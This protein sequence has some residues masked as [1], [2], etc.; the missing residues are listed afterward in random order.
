MEAPAGQRPKIGN[1]QAPGTVT[2]RGAAGADAGWIAVSSVVAV[3]GFAAGIPDPSP[4]VAMPSVDPGAV[5]FCATGARTTEARVPVGPDSSVD[6]AARTGGVPVV[7]AVA[8]LAGVLVVAVDVLAAFFGAAFPA[9]DLLAATFF[10]AALLA[11]R[12]VAALFFTAAFLTAVFFTDAFF[13]GA[14]LVG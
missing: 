12:F 7:F 5:F 1:G 4:F 6:R 3:A 14:A 13:P 10:G 2:G 8:R 9:A 11:T